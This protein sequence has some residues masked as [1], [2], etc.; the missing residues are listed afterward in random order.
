V[1]NDDSSRPAGKICAITAAD[2]VLKRRTLLRSGASAALLPLIASSC[3]TPSAA[4]PRALPVDLEETLDAF[5]DRIIPADASGPGAAA[6]GVGDFINRSLV[7]W[8]QAELPLLSAGLQALEQ[9]AAEQH[10]GQR[11]SALDP[12]SQDALLQAMEAGELPAFPSA[13][14]VFNRLHRLVLEGMFSD[15]Y[16][17]GNRDYAGWDL[18]GYPGAV[19]GST[20]EMQR[21][22]ARLPPLHTSAYGAEHDG[23]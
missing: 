3:S 5:A 2:P 9:H 8:N 21:M 23:H 20:V 14:Q 22:G 7:E 4:L 1:G 18:I 17:G 13:Q 12:T 19:L 15:P 6:S 16:Y 10:Q 11:F